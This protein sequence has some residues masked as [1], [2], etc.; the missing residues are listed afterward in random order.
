MHRAIRKHKEKIA[1]DN[2]LYGTVAEL[3]VADFMQF[4]EQTLMMSGALREMGSQLTVMAQA[5]AQL[6]P[7]SPA[8]AIERVWGTH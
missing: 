2:W 1:F 8:I 3:K 6:H 4:V 5:V 7:P